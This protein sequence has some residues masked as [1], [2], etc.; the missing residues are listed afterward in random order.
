ML[1]HLASS[2]PM[3]TN[4][5]NLRFSLIQQGRLVALYDKYTKIIPNKYTRQLNGI[6]N[7][8]KNINF[9]HFCSFADG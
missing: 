2:Q 3:N 9:Y 8:N 4:D 7:K 1:I 6:P 5:E